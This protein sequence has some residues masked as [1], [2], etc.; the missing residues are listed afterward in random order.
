M[1]DALPSLVRHMDISSYR[2]A[3]E[4]VV[5]LVSYDI[6]DHSV[7]YLGAY[8]WDRT[9]HELLFISTAKMSQYLTPIHLTS[10]SPGVVTHKQC[11]NS[12]DN[13]SDI[14]QC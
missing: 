10:S 4:L 8:Q 1:E 2:T 11:W 7:P 12:T 3:T 5:T 14:V 13:T 6:L 9:I